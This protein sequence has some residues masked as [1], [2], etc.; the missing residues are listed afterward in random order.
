[1]LN[2]LENVKTTECTVAKNAEIE[3][4]D[5]K[6]KSILSIWMLIRMIL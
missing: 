4:I 1:M 5:E 2:L 6:I 3:E